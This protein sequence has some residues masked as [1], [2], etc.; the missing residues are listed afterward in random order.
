MSEQRLLPTAVWS[1]AFW[2]GAL[3]GVV[4]VWITDE[5]RRRRSTPRLRLVHDASRNP[6]S[7]RAIPLKRDDAG[8]DPAWLTGSHT[9][10]PREFERPGGA[11]G[12]STAAEVQETPGRLGQPLS[13]DDPSNPLRSAAKTQLEPP[14]PS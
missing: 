13:H 1:S 12:G 8:G 9:P 3:C 10:S 7:T 11:P 5:L 14:N 6:R 2:S 4:A